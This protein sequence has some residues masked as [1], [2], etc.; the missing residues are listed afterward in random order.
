MRFSPL[1]LALLL[2]LPLG[3]QDKPTEKAEKK[4]APP[5]W[6]QG[7]AS[8]KQG[9]LADALASFQALMEK[10]P[11]DARVT[12]AIRTIR[13]AMTMRKLVQNPKHPK[14]DAAVLRLH[15]F[16]SVN[17]LTKQAL[18]LVREAWGR[19]KDLRFGRILAKDLLANGDESEALHLYEDLIEIKDLPDF[20]AQA[21]LLL[22]KFRNPDEAE[23]HLAAIPK[24]A[25]S[26]ALCYNM[27][28]IYALSG[29]PKA[30]FHCLKRSFELTPPS[31]LAALKKHAAKDGDL[32]SLDPKQ[33]AQVMKTRSTVSEPACGKCKGCPS[34]GSCDKSGEEGC[35]DK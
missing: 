6:T 30:A 19:K 22:L 33:L 14:Y 35:G 16:Y 18:E 29:R 28:C 21:A 23:K 12:R 24:E 31:R 15:T 11:G 7:V 3:A 20:R 13:T 9:K 4:P 25:E 1:T 5:E 32:S 10:K 17:G 26:S 34:K 27:A 2:A 8:L